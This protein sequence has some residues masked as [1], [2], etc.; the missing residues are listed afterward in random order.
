MDKV[1]VR[2]LCGWWLMSIRGIYNGYIDHKCP[3]C[4]RVVEIEVRECKA[5]VRYSKQ[6]A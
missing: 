2:C 4:K 3:K 6:S 1:K 5:E